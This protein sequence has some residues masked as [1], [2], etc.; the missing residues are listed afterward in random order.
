MS[1]SFFDPFFFQPLLRHPLRL[2][3][4]IVWSALIALMLSTPF[5]PPARAQLSSAPLQSVETALSTS[6][7]TGVDPSVQVPG[8]GGPFPGTGV[9]PSADPDR[10]GDPEFVPHTPPVAGVCEIELWLTATEFTTGQ[11]LSEGKGEMSS[12]YTATT[13]VPFSVN[14]TAVPAAGELVYSVGER[15]GHEILLGTYE[16]AEGD[17]LP[18]QVCANFREHDGGLIN[19]SDDVGGDCVTLPLSCVAGRGHAGIPE[20]PLSSTLCGD[21][22]CNGEMSAWVETLAAD[23]DGDGVINPD[24]FTPEI[25]DE[26][27]K[28]ENGIGLLLYFQYDDNPLITLAQSIGTNLASI[29]SAYDYV[30]LVADS[31]ESNPWAAN[32]QAFA[33]ADAVFPPTREGLMNAMQLLTS[34]GMRFDTF[35]HAHGYK[36]GAD[37]SDFETLAG[38]AH[39]SGEWLVEAT[40][41]E[42]IGT[43]RGGVPI[44]AVGGTNCIAL[45]QIDAWHEIGAITAKG[46]VDI[47]FFP[48]NWGP[49][50]SAWIGGERFRDAVENADTPAVIAATSAL[51]EA[52]GSV[53]P[54]W[55]PPSIAH[56]AGVLGNNPCAIDFFNDDD[57][58]GADEAAYPIQEVYD[59]SRT[60]FENM[61]ISSEVSFIGD[62]QIRFGGMAY[63]WP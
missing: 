58:S 34:E 46:T 56:P 62:D 29:Y 44:I 55:C 10:C 24:D 38:T 60:G 37:D 51:V 16:V 61:L 6:T 22:Q 20:T 4:P 47:A 57:G 31:A 15:K 11:G 40:A 3:K 59:T 17:T 25:C 42:L 54:W 12:V 39:I 21:N 7:S 30:V 23:A 2:L 41:P 53:H 33:D 50:S 13:T 43:A 36:N 45:R 18:V 48:L 52:Q 5:A 9:P 14:S 1:R 35:I 49:F 8:A 32:R 26:A 19:G 28:G 27:E 63:T